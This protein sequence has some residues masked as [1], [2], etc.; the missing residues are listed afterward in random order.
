MPGYKNFAIVGA[1]T[2]GSFVVRQ[3]LED[4]AAGI[5][6]QVVVLTREG[7]KKTIDGDAT[8]IPVDYSNKESIMRALTD[9]DVVIS[10][11]ASSALD[12]QIGI[13]EAAKE[14]GVR[15]FIPSEF[16]GSTEGKTEGMFGR[17]ARIHSQ[18][19]AVGIPYALFFTGPYADFLWAQFVSLDVTRGK[20]SV[21]GDGNKQVSFTS[22]SDIARYLSY[23][24][25][26]LPPEQLEN[27]TFTIAGDTKSFN[28]IFK[29]Y[30]AKTGKKLEVTYVPVS[31]LEARIA[32]NPQD[33]VAFVHKVWATTGPFGQTDNDLYPDWNP[34]SVLDNILRYIMSREMGE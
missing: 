29:E 27:R 4:K 9:I 13:A 20:V 18:L 15:L 3:F 12:L 33:F 32:A 7:S 8:V 25:T 2:T 17:K 26:H 1:G 5:V 34:T 14:A 31:D 30:D 16:G 11:I 22:R 23:V 28:E 6:N 21:G 24:L 10:T 19:K